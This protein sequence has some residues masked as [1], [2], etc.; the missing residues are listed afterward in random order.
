MR[1]NGI[2]RL[3]KGTEA[4]RHEGTKGGTRK[5]RKVNS[6]LPLCLLHHFVPSC[7][8]AFVPLLKNQHGVWE[9]RQCDWVFGASRECRKHM[10][11]SSSTSADTAVASLPSSRCTA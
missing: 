9:V 7:L 5:K 6:L 10:R 4:R 8:R 3:K 2:A 1:V 11:M